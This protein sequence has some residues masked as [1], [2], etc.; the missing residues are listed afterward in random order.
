VR[1]LGL[2]ILAVLLVVSCG[3]AEPDAAVTR[4]VA[5]PSADISRLA[6]TPLISRGLPAFASSAVYPAML[7]DD[8]RYATEFRGAPPTSLAYDLSGVPPAR[9]QTVLVAWYNEDSLWDAAAIRTAAY[10]LP[11]DYT[12]EANPDAG[13]GAEAPSEGWV[14]L[15]RVDGNRFSSRLHLVRLV[16]F[17]WLRMTVTAT[18]GSPDNTDAAFNLDLHDAG[19]S[20]ADTWLFSGDS[21]TQDDMSHRPDPGFAELVS[22]AAPSRFPAQQDGGIAGWASADPLRTDSTTGRQYLAEYLAAFPGRYVSL[23]FGTND[24]LQA[25]AAETYRANVARLVEAVE[26]AG[27]VPIVPLIPWGCA[28]GLAANGPGINAAI[29]HLWASDPRIVPGPDL[30]SY[31]QAHRELIGKDCIHPTLPDGASAYRQVYAEAMLRVG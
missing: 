28:P 20:A 22:A 2:G 30:W 29:R 12:I 11:R 24:A 25:V 16:G 1:Q 31:F 23:A 10:N 5:A 6:P 17:N 8:S 9:R 19:G 18:S 3:A 7:G 27:K 15:V 13:G 4:P 26:K 21:I 14:T